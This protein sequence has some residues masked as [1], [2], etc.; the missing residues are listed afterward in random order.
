MLGAEGKTVSVHSE[1]TGETYGHCS[2][3]CLELQFSKDKREKQEAQLP[4]LALLPAHSCARGFNIVSLSFPIRKTKE[5]C[6][7]SLLYP[8]VWNGCQ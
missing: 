5:I 6:H 4:A 8:Y 3:L 7:N 2:D 1:G